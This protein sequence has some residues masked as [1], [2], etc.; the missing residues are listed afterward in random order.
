M[1][2]LTVQP[3]PLEEGN[4]TWR[5]I[6]DMRSELEAGGPSLLMKLATIHELLTEEDASIRMFQ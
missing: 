1:G 4:P 6:K 2:T 3:L 5:M